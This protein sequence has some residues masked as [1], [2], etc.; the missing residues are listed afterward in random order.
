M[1]VQVKTQS[2]IFN[3]QSVVFEGLDMTTGSVLDT[4]LA[5]TRAEVAQRKAALPLT[6][7]EAQ[8]QAA[9]PVRSFADALRAGR[10]VALIAEIKK[11]SP[12]RGVLLPNFDPLALAETYHASGAAALSV[13]TDERFFQGS[14]QYLHAIR[15]SQGLGAR[16]APLLRKD[17]ILDPYQ[18][19]E[20]RAH[21]ADALLLIVAALD[22]RA[23]RELLA[24]T[25]DWGMQALVEVHNEAELGRALAIGATVIG[26]NN[27]DLHSFG[28]DLA[29]T[30]RLA[31]LLPAH[32]KPVLV[33]ES[34]IFAAQDVAR[35]AA[36]GADAVLVGEALVVAGDIG[37]KVRELA[38]V[39][40]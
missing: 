11:A 14:L 30:E 17:F 25:V 8:A 39:A 12:S 33:A 2:A 3:L 7:L 21:G 13:L 34:G 10:H 40:R 6:R 19:V 35:L 18:V 27:R 28:V 37:A 5:N 29:A 24:L 20:A 4:I 1:G 32:N 23:L 38:G 36:C 26:V 9:P 16:H 15:H 31:A 22:D